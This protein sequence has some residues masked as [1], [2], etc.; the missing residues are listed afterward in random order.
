MSPRRDRRQGA[1]GFTLVEILVALAVLA[2]LATFAWRATASLVD[3][4]ARLTGEAKRWQALDALFARI[5]GDVAAALPRAVRVPGGR[6]SAWQ[7]TVDANGQSTFAFTRA[8]SD[9]GAEGTRIAYR[10]AGDTV[11]IAYW[12]RLDRAASARPARYALV[13]GISRFEARYAD[14]DGE[15]TDRWSPPRR[16]ELP[17]AVAITLTLAEGGRIERVMV[18]R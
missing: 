3:G 10:L 13:G 1:R 8:G 7:G 14:D 12:P 4:E 11:E 17:A 15:W 6:E 2:V 18:L 5:E 9:P 16:N